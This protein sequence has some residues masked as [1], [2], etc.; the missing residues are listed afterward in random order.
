MLVVMTYSHKA[1]GRGFLDHYQ[2]FSFV[3]GGHPGDEEQPGVLGRN[4][5]CCRPRPPPTHCDS[6]STPDAEA[7]IWARSTSRNDLAARGK[8]DIFNKGHDIPPPLKVSK[9]QQ[10]NDKTPILIV[11]YCGVF[12]D[13]TPTSAQRQVSAV[14]RPPP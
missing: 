3:W 1:K 6:A 8:S 2:P 7:K 5:L 9:L 13:E 14:I 12:R 4:D 10:K 11:F